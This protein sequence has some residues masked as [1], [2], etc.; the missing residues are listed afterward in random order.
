[1]R[2]SSQ[3]ADALKAGRRLL[4]V[5]I[6]TRGLRDV[7]D[8]LRPLAVQ[9]AGRS[10]VYLKLLIDVFVASARAIRWSGDPPAARDKLL[11]E[12]G[13]RALRPLLDALAG[14]DVALRARALEVIQATRAP[15]AVPALA[16]LVSSSD[17]V[18]RVAVAGALGMIGTGSASAALKRLFADGSGDAQ[19]IAILAL[20]LAEAPLALDVLMEVATSRHSQH[21]IRAAWAM[22]R[23]ADVRAIDTLQ[24]LA[25]SAD[26]RQ[27]V[28]ALWALGQ[29]LGPAV[30]HTLGRALQNS[31]PIERQIATQGLAR[32]GTA[33]A[34]QLLV[35]QLWAA[36]DRPQGHL[37][38]ALTSDPG[39]DWRDPV[40][41]AYAALI[42]PENGR[43][44]EESS[45]LLAAAMLTPPS[46][47]QR[48]E[49]TQ[50][51]LPLLAKRLHT[52]LTSGSP[53]VV[54]RVLRAFLGHGHTLT[55]TPLLPEGSDPVRTRA[56]VT[57]LWSDAS[58]ALLEL[59]AG[60]LGRSVQTDALR[61][62]TRLDPGEHSDQAHDHAME[63]LDSRWPDVQAAAVGLL[64]RER[65]T[66][67]RV[68][69][70]V[71]GGRLADWIA[72]GDRS[73]AVRVAVASALGRL[74]GGKTTQALRTLLEDPVTG[75]RLAA[76]AAVAE[77]DHHDLL[78]P[79]ADRVS[80][81]VA[82]VAH[83]AVEALE[84]S[85]SPRARSLL[86]AIS[87]TLA[88]ALAPG[89]RGFDSAP[90]P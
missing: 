49:A 6:A 2:E 12:L 81:P 20:G 38:D 44:K 61:L 3:P 82:D 41:H 70:P 46:G 54:E 11:Q 73:V 87:R 22:G 72:Q 66:N 52:V 60:T 19:R 71:L 5:A 21:R 33:A 47:A 43:F 68:D 57:A 34:K 67:G 7:E 64:A 56:L 17:T 39:D 77:L 50:A 58:E 45:P 90:S 62:L 74:G 84:R 85:S 15:G 48:L 51:L 31:D 79:L 4:Q 18:A 32:T 16:R 27:R 1:V 65:A 80:D 69:D 28:A 42:Q 78:E 30:T 25:R 63:A 86:R 35:N 10:D 53:R 24:R 23:R 36:D 83:A 76:I 59:A 9:R 55:L 88:P 26:A 13:E 29:I 8:A 40:E 14:S 75:V 89:S 37:G